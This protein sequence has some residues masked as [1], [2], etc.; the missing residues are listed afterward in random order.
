M[1]KLG[2]KEKDRN[3]LTK[4]FIH[5]M[6]NLDDH[7]IAP[8]VSRDIHE[9]LKPYATIPDAYEQE[10]IASN[11]EMMS[12]YN[13]LKKR[14]EQSK[15]PE[16]TALKIAIAGNIIDFGP[17]HQFNI[18]ET[19][20]HVLAND[21]SIDDSFTLFNKIRSSNKILWLGDNTGEIV[22]DKLLIEWLGLDNVVF[23]VRGYPVLNDATLKEAKDIGLDK[24][25]TL[26]SNGSNA[27][28]TLLNET[29]SEFMKHYRQ[30]DLIIS[31]G[32]GN[33]EGLMHENDPRIFFLLMVKCAYIG[34]LMGVKKGDF[35]VKA[36][37]LQELYV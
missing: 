17:G 8:M 10:K 21:F 4:E 36:N 6:D 34:N 33:L 9:L 20:D 15:H 32:Q 22:A 11:T 5:Y 28:S 25:T 27:P 16:L 30:A 24:I 7:V 23:A 18:L 3:Q 37:L 13:A 19:I 29:S 31:K 35:I 2:V 12:L 1:Q 26:I 14:I